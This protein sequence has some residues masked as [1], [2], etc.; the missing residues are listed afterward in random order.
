MKCREIIEHLNCLAPEMMA[1]SWDN[2]GLL[3]GRFEKE[4]KKIYLALDATDQVILAAA[5]AGADM[6]ITHHPLIFKAVKK[7]NDGDFIGRRLVALLQ[8]DISY[9]A[10]HTNFDSAPGCMADMAAEKMGL[11]DT[12]VLEPE[13]EID[14]VVYGIGKIGNLEKEVSLRE[15]AGLVK[16]RFGLF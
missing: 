10:M 14:G 13:G 8:A 7:V 12:H 1:C 16:E 2:P 4:V 6:L 3:A 5:A 9:Y 11:T 15:L